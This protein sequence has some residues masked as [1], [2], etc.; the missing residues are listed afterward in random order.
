MSIPV[1]YARAAVRATMAWCR[2]T[3][4][5]IKKPGSRGENCRGL[6]RDGPRAYPEKQRARRPV[7]VGDGQDNRGPSPVN[8]KD[9]K[10][11]A[12]FFR[13]NSIMPKISAGLLMFRR[14]STGIEVLLVHPGGPLWGHKD[15]G[16]WSIPKGEVEPGEDLL[17]AAQREFE[18]ETG[19]ISISQKRQP[20][21]AMTQRG[22]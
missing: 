22:F 10:P 15:D 7:A 11:M 16:F 21:A 17:A 2:A 3:R 13:Y 9:G 19:V 8:K 18:E 6:C 14:R 1:S 12:T 4:W 5:Q 20:Q